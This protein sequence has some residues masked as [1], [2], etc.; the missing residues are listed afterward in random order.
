MLTLEQTDAEFET[1]ANST[2]LQ[3]FLL[4]KRGVNPAGKH[5]YIYQRSHAVGERLGKVFGFEVVIPKVV[6]AGTVYKFPGGAEK[7]IAEDM[8]VYPNGA[9]TDFGKR[10][11]FCVTLESAEKRFAIITAVPIEIPEGEDEED[12]ASKER[13]RPKAERAPLTLP[14]GEFSVTEVAHKNGVEYIVASQFVKEKVAAGLLKVGRK[15][16]RAARGKETQLYFS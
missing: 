3:Q 4:I 6:K 10:A 12:D 1:N 16:R 5:V 2:G 7:T 15:E 13:G 9:K 14:E 11:W 8:E